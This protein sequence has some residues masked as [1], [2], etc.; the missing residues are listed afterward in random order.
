ME[1]I[2]IFL[3]SS[4]KEFADTR[5]ELKDF[6]RCLNDRLVDCGAYLYLFI[7]EYADNAIADEGK[8]PEYNREL[9]D[10]NL[11]F[12]L[13]G[14]NI[15]QFTIEEY[16]YAQKTL[17]ERGNLKIHIVLKQCDT[18]DASVMEFTKKLPE[19]V[20]RTD[21]A[22][23]RELKMLLVSAIS[24]ELKNISLIVDGG[25]AIVNGKVAAKL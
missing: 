9:N 5:L 3:A 10:S 11:C 21:F 15:G 8:Q 12:L 2:K 16:D 17:N 22:E 23:T 7:C 4:I 24:K 19:N 25:F 6:V 20:T 13:V 1:K 14:Q 18:V